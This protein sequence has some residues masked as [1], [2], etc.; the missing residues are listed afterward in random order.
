[1]EPR[2]RNNTTY[3]ATM[4]STLPVIG[5]TINKWRGRV[6]ILHEHPYDADRLISVGYA[7]D[8]SGTVVCDDPRSAWATALDY[9]AHGNVYTSE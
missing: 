1:M 7:F 2:Y 5:Q 6:V 9:I 4:I 3:P 8:G